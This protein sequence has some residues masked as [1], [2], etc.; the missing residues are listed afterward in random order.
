MAQRYSDCHTIV[1]EDHA[2]SA[3]LGKMLFSLLDGNSGLLR[4]NYGWPDDIISYGKISEIREKYGMTPE[5]IAD[6]ILK[7]IRNF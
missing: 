6:D 2:I 5:L 1:I 3:G 4:L 7:K